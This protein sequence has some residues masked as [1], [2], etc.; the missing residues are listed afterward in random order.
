MIKDLDNL[1]DGT[2]LTEEGKARYEKQLDHLRTVRRPQVSERIR[3]AREFGDISE[4][5]EYES[6]KQEQAFI[7]GKITELEKL[8]KNAII[9]K[10]SEINTNEVNLGT[11]VK[12]EDLSR[13]EV[14]SFSITGTLEADPRHGKLSNESPVGA[15]LMGHGVGDEVDVRTP[16]GIVTW[17]VLGIEAEHEEEEEEF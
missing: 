6:A 8:L 11:I 1:N 14:F 17:K 5:A 2:H 13:N 7:E 10:R 4:N 3:T 15:A 9:I 12:V 16:D